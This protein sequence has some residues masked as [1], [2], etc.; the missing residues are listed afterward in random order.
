MGGGGIHRTPSRS[1]PG[2]VRAFREKNERVSLSE[3]KLIVPNFKVSGQ[4]DNL[5]GQVKHSKQDTIVDWGVD[6]RN[7]SV[8]RLRDAMKLAG[9]S[10]SA[11]KERFKTSRNRSEKKNRSFEVI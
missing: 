10:Q 6:E 4:T 9:M 11:P 5:R 2:G 8:I 7:K 3:T 1:A